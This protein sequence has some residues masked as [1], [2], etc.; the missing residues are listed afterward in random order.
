MT[1]ASLLVRLSSVVVVLPLV[2]NRFA[3]VEV[4]VW[5]LFSSILTLTLLLDLGFA[6]TFSRLF[7]YALGGAGIE[8]MAAMQCEARTADQHR[9]AGDPAPTVSR[10]FAALLWIYP[11]LATGSVALFSVVGTVILRELIPQFPDP[12]SMWLAWVVVLVG[13]YA[14]IVGNA[15]SVV[16]QGMN[17]VAL[18]KRLDIVLGMAQVLSCFAVL[19]L[20]GGILALVLA[21]QAW[22]VI[23]VLA[24]RILV[25]QRFSYLKQVRPRRDREVLGVLWP[26]AW[27]S[28]VGVLM[29]HGLIQASGL[30]YS[31]LASASELASYLLAI[32]VITMVSQ[33]SQAPFYSKLPELARLHAL[34]ESGRCLAVARRGMKLAQAFLSLGVVAVALLSG[35]LLDLID[36]KIPFVPLSLWALIAVAF[37]V[38][39][40]GAMH[41]QLYS[42]T[43]HI[44]WHIA[45]G[46]TGTLMITTAVGLYP[47][48]GIV[49]LPVAMLIAYS[50]F[51]APYA[52][53]ASSRAFGFSLWRFETGA[54]IPTFVFMAGALGA[55]ALLGKLNV[56]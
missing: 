40:F 48:L 36:S 44:T 39:R 30:V 50:I 22:T 49:A 51:Y 27:R 3:P 54:S 6:P 14:G 29:S 24:N 37:F 23:G 31:Q 17:E 26:S 19:A 21:Y 43:N 20:G 4:A 56:S 13:A 25:S 5:M 15:F 53:R 16:L 41:L 10:V 42:V 46:V 52:S 8:R 34:G 18:Q 38:E 33:V 11:R 2:L 35:T 55:I 28:G 12:A 7:S 1:W 47:S 45:N 9:P 32:R